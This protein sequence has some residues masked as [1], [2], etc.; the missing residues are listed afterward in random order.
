MERDAAEKR[1]PLLASEVDTELYFPVQYTPRNVTKKKRAKTGLE[2]LIQFLNSF[3][4][5]TC[6]FNLLFF[7]RF[8]RIAKLMFPCLLSKTLLFFI[9]LMFIQIASEIYCSIMCFVY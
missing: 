8:Y 1:E 5:N 6:R 9:F 4:W 3:A 2:P 7:K